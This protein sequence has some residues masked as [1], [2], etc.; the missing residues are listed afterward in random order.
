MAALGTLQ[1]RCESLGFLAGDIWNRG[2]KWTDTDL[3][4]IGIHVHS[5][6]AAL[7]DLHEAGFYSPYAGDFE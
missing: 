4:K 6:Q 5:L 1:H 7:N 2:M 3:I